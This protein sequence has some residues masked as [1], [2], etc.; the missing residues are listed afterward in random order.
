M[1]PYIAVYRSGKEAYSGGF[2][3][4]LRQ[5]KTL[6]A[7][8]AE[9]T[10]APVTC[11]ENVFPDWAYDYVKEG[12]IAMVSG[13]GRHT[14]R[15][16]A[17]FL[18]KAAVEWIDLSFCNMGKARI[19]SSVS[20]F[21]G[22]GTGELT[23][24]E[25]RNIK[26]GRRPGFYPVFLQKDYGRGQI[27]YTG[28]PLAELLTY[29]G[30]TLRKTCELLDFDERISS[31]DKQKAAAALRC[32]LRKA[33]N[34]AGFPYLSLWYFPDKAKSVFAYSID[35][36]GL[37]KEG[38]DDL[39]EVSRQIDTKF[40]FYINKQL[41]EGDPDL[42]EKLK[43]IAETNLIAS[44]GALHNAHDSYEDNIRDIE[45]HESW[46]KSLDIPF[47]KSFASPRGMYCANLGRAL[48][49]K[50]FRHSRDFGYYIDDY[51]CFPMIE[52]QQAAPLQIPTDGFNVCRWMLKNEEEGLPMPSWEEI[53]ASYKTIIDLKISRNQPLLFFCHPQYFGLYA[54]Q[55]YPKLV[56]YA[57]SKGAAIS[58]YLA[59]GDFWIA[60][61]ECTYDADYADGKL[62]LCFTRKADGVNLCV[63]GK[64]IDEDEFEM[65]WHI[66]VINKR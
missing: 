16:D 58:D 46:M 3:Q 32:L 29:E 8:S 61:D 27:I 37:L 18:C 9:K 6:H 4:L 60:R 34:R 62:K 30:S 39:I 63:D 5:E 42:K 24:H 11:F 38:I 52:G 66:T 59:Y 23:L 22:E 45:E 10:D 56:D 15:F 55:L 21:A 64:I 31:V 7:V 49:D 41:C 54:K 57:R 2:E 50:G 14:F 33:M 40:L 12:G 26:N 28:V 65:D 44:H 19:C 20:V 35:G 53:F 47:E 25:F 17:G 48:K 43:R 1:R 36:D 13:A 51:P